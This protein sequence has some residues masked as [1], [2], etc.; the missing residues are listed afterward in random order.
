M[1]LRDI[2]SGM[3]TG[4]RGSMAAEMILLLPIMIGFLLGTIEFSIAFYSRQQLLTATR[5]GARVGAHGGTDTEI[6]TTV[7]SYLGTGPLG[8]ATVTV[9]RTAENPS[10]PNGRALVQVCSTVSTTH[11][12]PNLLPW[13]VNLDGETLTA[14]VTMNLE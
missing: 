7:Q 3:R 6:Q 2:N 11:V 5:E 9:T 4:R 1:R 8:D 13:M 12:V 14:C 10:N